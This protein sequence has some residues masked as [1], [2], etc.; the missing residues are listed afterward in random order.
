MQTIHDFKQ[1]KETQIDELIKNVQM[2]FAFSNEQLKENKVPL[3]EGDKY[4]SLGSGCFLPKSQY[5]NYK[6]GIKKIETEFKASVKANKGMKEQ[7]IKYQLANHE[8]WYTGS[9]DDTLAA[10][11][12]GYT[13]KEVWKVY[14]ENI[15]YME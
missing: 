4:L 8:A 11:G 1:I 6:N 3:K 9:I 5:E 14:N 12:E 7:N 13:K 15:N 2:F 10:L